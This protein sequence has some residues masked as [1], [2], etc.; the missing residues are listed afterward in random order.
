[1]GFTILV[2]LAFLC[3]ICYTLHR[4]GRDGG[5]AIWI[6]VLIFIMVGNFIA[7]FFSVPG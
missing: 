2:W 4:W 6:A 5:N 3:G 1:M 7:L